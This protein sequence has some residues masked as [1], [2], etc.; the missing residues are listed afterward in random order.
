MDQTTGGSSFEHLYVKER[1]KTRIFM[2]TTG[3]AVVLALGSLVYAG[4]KKADNPTGAPGLGSNSGQTAPFGGQGG[5]PGGDG[6]MRMQMDITNFLNDD[7]NVDTEQ[8]NEMLD[9]IPDDFR[10]D[11]LDRMEAQIDEATQDGDI[12]SDQ[13]T[14]LKQAFGITGETSES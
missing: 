4:N 8:I 3:M 1:K 2:A 5:G 11:M 13:A 10:E 9:R 7:G 12:T 6:G 14:A